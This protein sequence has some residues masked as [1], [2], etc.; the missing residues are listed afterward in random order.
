MDDVERE[1][2]WQP[3]LRRAVQDPAGPVGVGT[4]KRY[5]SLFLGRKIENV[6]RVTAYEPD[7]RAVYVATPDSAVEARAEFLWE[8]VPGGTR[9]TVRLEARPRGA[10]R[11]LPRGVVQRASL[12]ELETMLENLRR[13]LSPDGPG[14]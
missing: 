12:A 11:F 8:S 4:R 9:V 10:L 14:A 1:H 13:I 6:Y 2:E 3:N 5:T 7:R